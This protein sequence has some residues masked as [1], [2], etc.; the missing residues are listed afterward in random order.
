MGLTPNFILTRREITIPLDIMLGTLQDS[1]KTT[2]PEYVRKAGSQFLPFLEKEPE[3]IPRNYIRNGLQRERHRV[4]EFWH[5]D[6]G[7]DPAVHSHLHVRHPSSV[8]F[9][10]A[11]SRPLSCHPGYPHSPQHAAGRNGWDTLQLDVCCCANIPDAHKTLRIHLN[12]AHGI[13]LLPGCPRSCF[14]FHSRWSDMKKHCSSHHHLDI[15][16]AHS[17]VGLTPVNKRDGKP[18]YA[19]IGPEDLCHYPLRTETLD[20]LQEAVVAKA[21]QAPQPRTSAQDTKPGASSQGPG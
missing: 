14:Y 16:S 3:N 13:E 5:E 19:G 7:S 8:V 21:T 18:T 10:V 6:T 12:R 1:Q 17:F 15:D 2:A 4:T 11:V 20:T 9:Q